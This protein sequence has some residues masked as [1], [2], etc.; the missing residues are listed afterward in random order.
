MNSIARRTRE[1]EATRR[2]IMEAAR[3]LFVR[4]GVAGVTMRRIAQAIEY[5]P[6]AIYHHFADKDALLRELCDHDFRALAQVFLRVGRIPDPVERL[7]AIGKAYLRFGLEHREQYRFMFMT[8]H[9]DVPHDKRN[10]EKGNPDEDAYAF[11]REAVR[12]AIAGGH[13]AA[14]FQDEEMVAQMLWAAVHGFVALRITHGNDAWIDWTDA[15]ATGDRLMDTVTG[16][17]VR[18][19]A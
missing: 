9:V 1:K 17:L 19:P 4:E 10:L 7:R 6:T 14:P 8:E 13:L 12:D 5:T 16:G 18:G 2:R 15:L 3:E 11:L